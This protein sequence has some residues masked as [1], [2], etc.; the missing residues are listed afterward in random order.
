MKN[1][2]T[3]T[4]TSTLQP[5]AHTVPPE[6]Q[7][8]SFKF[9]KEAYP[10]VGKGKFAKIMRADTRGSLAPLVVLHPTHLSCRMQKADLGPRFWSHNWQS[11]LAD[12]LRLSAVLLTIRYVFCLYGV[13][14]YYCSKTRTI[15]YWLFSRSRF[16]VEH[17][18]P[19]AQRTQSLRR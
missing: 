1:Q 14:H 10:C 17:P 16:S 6:L 4:I 18:T 19:L 2:L 5:S 12:L 3:T 8:H 15:L 9:C 11:P 13:D 7:S